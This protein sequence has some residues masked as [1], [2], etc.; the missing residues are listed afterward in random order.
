M[1]QF[2]GQGED[3][4]ISFLFKVYD[5]NGKLLMNGEREGGGRETEREI[6]RKRD[7]KRGKKE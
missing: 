1:H 7:K 3:E 6:K 5:L 2:S 4:K